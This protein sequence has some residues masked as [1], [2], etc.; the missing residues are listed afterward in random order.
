MRFEEPFSALMDE[1]VLKKLNMTQSTYEQTLPAGLYAQ[2]AIGYAPNGQRPPFKW[3]IHPE[4]AAAGLWTTPSDLARFAIELQ[5]AYAGKS[6]RILS[7]EMVRQMLTKQ[8]RWLGTRYHR[9]RRW[10]KSIAL[11]S[12]WRQHGISD[13]HG[14]VCVDRSGRDRDD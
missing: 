4:M 3:F 5:Q 2:A 14:R 7:R 11:F 6:K 1:T 8:G 9:E 10:T 12:W 13:P